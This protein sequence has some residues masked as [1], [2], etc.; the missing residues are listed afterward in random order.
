MGENTNAPKQ[1]RKMNKL[2]SEIKKLFDSELFF[3]LFVFFQWT[4]IIL[5]IWQICFAGSKDKGFGIILFVIILRFISLR[6]EKPNKNKDI[7]PE[8]DYF[9]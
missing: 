3:K 6:Y 5:G 8:D 9:R 1:R 4:L 2:I 7:S